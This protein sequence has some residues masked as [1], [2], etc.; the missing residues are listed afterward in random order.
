MSL[1]NIS[2]W[3]AST[4]WKRA[5]LAL[6]FWRGYLARVP[7]DRVIGGRKLS[8]R[9]APKTMVVTPGMATEGG[10]QVF[11][12]R[13]TA[14]LSAP[15]DNAVSPVHSGYSFRLFSATSKAVVLDTEIHSPPCQDGDKT[16]D[17]SHMVWGVLPRTKHHRPSP[18]PKCED[19]MYHFRAANICLW[20]GAWMLFLDCNRAM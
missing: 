10:D 15:R 2:T 4:P 3:A 5:S 16:K 1:N 6:A 13:L 11:E 8:Q 7:S 17:S 20:S 14:S 18:L 19:S 12:K 9:R